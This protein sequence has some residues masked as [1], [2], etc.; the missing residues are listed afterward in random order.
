MSEKVKVW[1]QPK[2][3]VILMLCQIVQLSFSTCMEFLCVY[4]HLVYSSHIRFLFEYIVTFNIVQNNS[5]IKPLNKKYL[6][7]V[8]F[9][10]FFQFISDAK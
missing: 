9:F 5:T 3:M 1:T 2:T 8:F 10:F 6:I 4:I 7:S